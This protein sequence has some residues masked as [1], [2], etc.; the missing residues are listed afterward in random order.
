[1][2]GVEVPVVTTVA[3]YLPQFR[4]TPYNDEWWGP[5]FTEWTQVADA[6]PLFRGHSQ[7]RLPGELG[8]YDLRVPETRTAQAKLATSFG[9]DC[10]CY[11]HYWFAGRRLLN[12]T[13]DEVLLQMSRK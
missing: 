3:F 6:T 8:F 2:S 1:M 4:P 10:F 7:P 5:G 9:I 13:F 11:W 12:E